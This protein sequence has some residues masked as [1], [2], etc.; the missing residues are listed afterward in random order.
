MSTVGYMNNVCVIMKK[1][2]YRTNGT[3]LFNVN[4]LDLSFNSEEDL[5]IKEG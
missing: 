1:M 5:M 2:T 3:H 4:G